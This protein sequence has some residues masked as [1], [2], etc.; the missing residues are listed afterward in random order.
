MVVFV[1]GFQ[2]CLTDFI[3][4]IYHIFYVGFVLVWYFF[5]GSKV[6]RF[7]HLS[8]KSHIVEFFLDCQNE[9]SHGFNHQPRLIKLG[10]FWVTFNIRDKQT[11]NNYKKNSIYLQKN[12]VH[13]SQNQ[14]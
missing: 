7:K 8:E 9:L 11:L 4:K 2:T 1:H 3:E 14:D 13:N 12:F 5:G 10:M 6:F